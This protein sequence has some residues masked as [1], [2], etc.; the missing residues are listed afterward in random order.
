MK[1][2]V[3]L[4]EK[5]KKSKVGGEEMKKGEYGVSFK[6][7][8]NYDHKGQPLWVSITDNA[9]EMRL[10]VPLSKNSDKE[11]ECQLV[12]FSSELFDER[13]FS[14]SSLPNEDGGYEERGCPVKFYDKPYKECLVRPIIWAIYYP[15]KL[16]KSLIY[17][18]LFKR[19]LQ[20]KYEPERQRYSVVMEA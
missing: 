3:A 4:K 17:R 10:F 12:L 19:D 11:D 13:S 16:G 6:V 15:Q 18:F 7:Y 14:R 8:I 2:E 20:K 1:K 9:S 5:A